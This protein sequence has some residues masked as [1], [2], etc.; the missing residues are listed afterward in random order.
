VAAKFKA[1]QFFILLI[2]ILSLAMATR[3]RKMGYQEKLLSIVF[4]SE[5]RGIPTTGSPIPTIQSRIPTDGQ[6]WPEQIGISGRI[7]SESAI[8]LHRNQW[9][10]W[11]GI[12]SS[13]CK[14]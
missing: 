13:C 7:K 11:V 8:G 6:I 12:C 1:Q 9:S 2:R 5:K 4:K 3:L 14:S 10:V